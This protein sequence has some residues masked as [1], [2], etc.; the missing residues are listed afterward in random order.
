MKI[1]VI[2]DTHG[3]TNRAFIAHTLSEPVDAVIHLGDGSAD[4]DVLRAV[5]D[6]PVINVAGNCDPGA[7]APREYV[8]ECEGKRILL[9]HGDLYQVKFGLV[10]LRQRAKDTGVDAVLFGHTHQSVLENQNGLLLVN[11]GSLSNAC[12]LRSYAVL[13]IT[14]ED[15]TVRHY[16]ID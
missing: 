9:T 14:P 8:W 2:S 15:I 7:N 12:H 16:R 6:I 11:P 4:A 5:L 13:I 10:K 1:L 3:N